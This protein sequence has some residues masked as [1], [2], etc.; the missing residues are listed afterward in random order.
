MESPPAQFLYT[1]ETKTQSDRPVNNATYL[2]A[3]TKDDPNFYWQNSGQVRRGAKVWVRATKRKITPAYK[4]FLASEKAKRESELEFISGLVGQMSM[5]RPTSNNNNDRENYA[6]S[7]ITGMTTEERKRAME[8][9][10][11]LKLEINALS[12]L[13]AS[14]GMEGGKKRRQTRRKH[15]KRRHTKCK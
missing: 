8:Q 12:D 14:S 15:T 4:S 1:Y 3:M 11:K 2:S 7:L 9:A 6:K 10:A 13:M 5:I